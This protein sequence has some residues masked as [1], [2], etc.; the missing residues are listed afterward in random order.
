MEQINKY[1]N[2]QLAS[3][4]AYETVLL[5]IFEPLRDHVRPFDS[6]IYLLIFLTK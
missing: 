2:M 6:W 5:K 4:V 3:F 1:W